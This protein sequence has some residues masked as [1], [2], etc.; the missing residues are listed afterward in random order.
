MNLYEVV[1]ILNPALT[2]EGKDALLGIIKE[3]SNAHGGDIV[4]TDDWGDKRLQF[5][6]GRHTQGHYYLVYA[7]ASSDAVKEL[8][9]RLRLKEDVIRFM[10]VRRPI[11]YFEQQKAREERIV[12]KKLEAEERARV[13]AEAAAAAAAKSEARSAPRAEAAPAPVAAAPAAVTEGGNDGEPA[14]TQ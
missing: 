4:R 5:Q 8:D 10:I 7:T 11:D 9:R 13:K 1:V 12:Q 3:V 2:G 14:V 6:I